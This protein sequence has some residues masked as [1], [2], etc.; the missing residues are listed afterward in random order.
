MAATGVLPFVRGVDFSRNDFNVIKF[1]HNVEDMTSLRWLRLAR[2]QI[3]EIPKEVEKLKKLEDLMLAH[4][5]IERLSAGMTNLKSLSKLNCRHNQI[6][7]DGVPQGLFNLQDLSVVDLSHNKLKEVPPDLENAKSVLVLN[8]AHN[9]IEMLPNQLFINLLDLFFVDLSDNVLETLPPQLRRLTSLQTLILNNNPLIHAQLRQL[10]ALTSL[11]TLHMKNTQRTLANFPTGLDALTNLQDIDLSYN[12]LPRVPEALYKLSSLRRLNLCNNQ[13]SELSLMI[14]VWTKL[15]TLNLS[16]NQLTALPTS[17]HKLVSLRKLYVNSNQLDF[18]GIPPN[19]GKLHNLEIFSAADN[20]LEMIP[21]GLCRCGK[22]KKLIL[23]K[24]RLITLPDIL[25]LL[26]ELETLDVR[27][28]P[29]LVMP[30]KPAELRKAAEY[31]NI[32]FSLNNQLRLAGAA[33]QPTAGEQSTPHKDPIARKLRLRRRRDGQESEKVLKGMREVAKEKAAHENSK[34]EVEREP[35]KP[36]RW[37][38][39]LT[40]PQLDYREIFDEAVGQI[41]GLTSWEIENFLPNIVEEALVGKFYEADCYIVLKTFIDDT[42]SLGWQI[43][44]WIGEK[45]TLD[46]KACAAI[47]AV[48]LRN[49]LGAN[50]RTIRV[51]MN[52]EDDD[53]FDLFE[54][55]IAYI[56]GGRTASG[57]FTVEDTEYET[58]LYKATGTQSVHMERCP[59]NVS[60]LD[61]RHVFLL[62][63]GLK[64]FVWVGKTSKGVTKTKTR[65]ISEKIN[66]NERKNKAEIFV[67]PQGQETAEFWKLV[68]GPPPSLVVKE[69][70]LSGIGMIAPRLYR[71]ELGKG[72]LNLPQ[73]EIPKA[74]LVQRLLDTKCVYILDCNSDVFVWIGKKST[75]L[76]R[77]AALKLSQELY[78]MMERPKYASVSRCLEGGEQQIFKT[79]FVGWDDVLPVDYTRTAE[80]VIRRGADLKVIM[81]RDKMKTDLSALFMPRQPGMSADEAETLASEWNEDLDGMESFVLEGK[82]FVRLPEEEL[83]V[84]YSDDSYVFL[85]RYWVPVELPEGEEEDEE[86]VP[87]DE[88]KCIVYFWQGRTA[89]NMGW[90]TFTFS[91]QKKFAALFQDKLEVVRQHQQ[92]ENLKFLS[93]FKRKFVIRTGKRPLKTPNTESV[94]PSTEFFQLRANGSPIATR[95]VQIAPASASL[96]NSCFCYILMVPFDSEDMHGIVYVWVGM[97]ADHDEAKLAEQIAYMMYKDEYTIQMINEGEEPENFFWVG[98]GGQRPYD[99]DAEFMKYCRLFRCSNEK[100]YFTVSEK[101]ADFCQDDLADD[102]VMILDNGEQVFLWVGKKT[103][104]VEIKLAFKS[105]QVYIQHIRIKQPERPR[106]LLL[107]MKY[108]EHKKFTKCF[109]GWGKYKEVLK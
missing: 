102:D 42:N 96:L 19:V 92:Q 55:G 98:I 79:K 65:L 44:Y 12:D 20:N 74:K 84:F 89:S 37:D 47:H 29:D 100:G 106:K 95:C 49:L 91:L 23:N 108:K 87:E 45:A 75:R 25:H 7:N 14:D 93:H 104:D 2:T 41:P 13:I 66:K 85:C 48:N 94:K 71:V 52:D 69:S 107:A 53:F 30:P 78:S 64:L 16:R 90:L 54:N 1:P 62:D 63:S 38:E 99:H 40:R 34:D 26:P 6:T 15:E 27:E 8:V 68:G 82:K 58:K 60:S 57:F 67:L 81:E 9:E 39:H 109:H 72:Y 105:A 17:L 33:P 83:G 76:I 28:N 77:A 88:Y 101:C 31:Y 11:Q 86:D 80:S 97:K 73:V 35:A 10:P 5:N 50:C 24:N 51:E 59:V 46:K 70:V 4:N 43:W 36:K 18:D 61:C 3:T 22:L 32:D 103:S 21:E 56:E